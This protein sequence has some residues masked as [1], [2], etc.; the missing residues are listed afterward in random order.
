[1]MPVRSFETS[2]GSSP[3]S[4]IAWSMAMWFQAVPPPWKRI[5]RRSSTLGG[6]ELRRAVHLAAEAELLVLL[7][8]DDAGA[9]LAQARQHLL[10]VVADR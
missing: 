4:W 3:E 2:S 7:R 8:E 5:A 10:G 9:R 1:M 6:I